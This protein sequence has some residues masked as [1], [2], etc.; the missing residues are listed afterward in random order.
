MD[1]KL[2]QRLIG[3]IVILALIV[4]F[5]PMLF[6]DKGEMQVKTVVAVPQPPTQ[7]QIPAQVQKQ[8]QQQMPQHQSIA[9]T[10]TLTPGQTRALTTQQKNVQKLL[11]LTQISAANI[12]FPPQTSKPE[13][14]KKPVIQVKSTTVKISPVIVKSVRQKV[15]AAKAPLKIATKTITKSHVVTQPAITKINLRKIDVSSQNVASVVTVA[16]KPTITNPKVKLVKKIKHHKSKNIPKLIRHK[17]S[18]HFTAPK[19]D[20]KVY[21]VQLGAFATAASA[22]KL[23]AH[24]RSKGFTSFGYKV[25]RGYKVLTRV[26]VGPA[27][28]YVNA[29]ARCRQLQ[30]LIHTPCMVVKF[31]AAKLY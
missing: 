4:I 9:S 1:I 31:N 18:H 14:V 17:R 12:N 7:P 15:V 10:T 28:T 2:K 6:K 30:K 21:V 29:K 5:V 20:A 11:P 3:A 16:A 23:I 27:L 24:L 8:A 25:R 13:V 22:E 26:Y 19:P